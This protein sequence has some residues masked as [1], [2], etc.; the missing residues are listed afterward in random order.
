MVRMT[1]VGGM[2]LTPKSLARAL[3]ALLAVI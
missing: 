1:V 2:R 3:A